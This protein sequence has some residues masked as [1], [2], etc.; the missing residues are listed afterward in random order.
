MLRPCAGD[1]C[2]CLSTV[3]ASSAL[4]SLHRKGMGIRPGFDAAPPTAKHVQGSQSQGGPQSSQSPQPSGMP[5]SQAP[6]PVHWS[7][8]PAKHSSQPGSQPMQEQY[9]WLRQPDWVTQPAPMPHALG[10]TQTGEST[11]W[12]GML[13]DSGLPS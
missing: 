12:L 9:P 1:H 6:S 13:M 3:S 10:G 11:D 4:L 2:A 5:R 8:G 7:G